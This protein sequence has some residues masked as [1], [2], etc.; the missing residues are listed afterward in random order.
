MYA[1]VFTDLGAER[2][3]HAASFA[4]TTA[5]Q[6]RYSVGSSPPVVVPSAIEN[7]TYVDFGGGPVSPSLRCA[8]VRVEDG[9]PSVRAGKT[10]NPAV[11]APGATVDFT[12]TAN[13]VNGDST[14]P[15]VNPIISDWLPIQLEFVSLVSTTPAGGILQVTPDFGT[16]G[17]TLVRV[18]SRA[19]SRPGRQVRKSSFALAS[20][21]VCQPIPRPPRPM[22]MTWPYSLTR[23]HPAHSPVPTIRHRWLTSVISTTMVQRPI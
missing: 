7:C 3:R 22:S 17:R 12:L 1:L 9:T 4:F 23:V 10:S 8:N 11:A 18:A 2:P 14:A 6:V 5:P 21:R 15:M 19:V 20:V 13:H 16:P